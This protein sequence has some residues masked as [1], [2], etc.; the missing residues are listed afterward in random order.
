VAVILVIALVSSSLLFGGWGL[1]AVKKLKYENM[2]QQ[3]INV[4]E[5]QTLA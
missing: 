1:L 3:D 2:K 5:K 4:K